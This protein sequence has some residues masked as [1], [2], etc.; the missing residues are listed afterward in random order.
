MSFE[1][2]R[3][4]IDEVI[5]STHSADNTVEAFSNYLTFLHELDIE[6][7]N[8]ILLNE[9]NHYIHAYA[10]EAKDPDQ[11]LFWLAELYEKFKDWD[12]AVYTYGKLLHLSPRS[13]LIPKCQFQIAYN[14]CYQNL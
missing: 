13:S 11:H 4:V 3:S 12:E 7:I 9:L 8:E 6:D 2:K 14:F 5:S 1:E 10:K